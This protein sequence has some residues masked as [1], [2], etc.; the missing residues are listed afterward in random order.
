MTNRR[1]LLLGGMGAVGLAAAVVRS[2][3]A[4]A[5]PQSKG[6][7]V[8]THSLRALAEPTGLRIGTAVNADALGD[9]ATYRGIV[10]DQFSVVTAENAMKWGPLEPQRGQYAWG[11]ADQLVAFA[12]D[13]DQ[14]V[15]GHTL[16]WHNQLPDWLAGGDF[17]AAELHD[18]MIKHIDDV[19]GRY[20]GRIWQWDVVNEAFDDDGGLRQSI[21]STA[22]GE[23]FIA[24]AFIR[25]HR[26]DP[27]ALL[28]YNDYNIE[29]IGAKSDAVYELVGRLLD[30][31]VPIHGV[32][33][34][35]HLGTQYPFPDR[36]RDNL[37]RF[38]DLGLALAL[39][40][41]DIR[42]ELPM[43]ATKE[44]AQV[45]DYSQT[46]QLA[47]AVGACISYTVWGFSDAYSWVPGTFEGQ[48]SACLY[49][50]DLQPKPVVDVLRT[51]LELAAGAPKRRLPHHPR[52]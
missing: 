40:E 50:E 1:T 14:R 36:M 48:G 7:G 30:R 25:A 21:W 3:L 47:L 39:T 52:G 51:D 23:D 22:L 19:V 10:S 15:R 41:V 31:G 27:H 33:L 42:N 6:T 38:A 29:G 35:T 37:E 5:S 9:N 20:R 8:P 49:D 44:L 13:H 18:L 26:A 45:A 43:D 12:A 28:F 2:Q 4:A 24:D 11:Q 32:G 46:L 16:V 34:Q 17:S